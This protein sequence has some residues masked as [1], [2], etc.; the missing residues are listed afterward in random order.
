ML[1][2]KKNIDLKELEKYGYELEDDVYK[3]Y[4]DGN[5]WEVI[6]IDVEDRRIDKYVEEIG[7]WGIYDVNKEDIADLI[8]ADL[9]ERGKDNV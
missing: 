7:Y 4:I 5:R 3:K 2:I 9:I 6:Y 1:K 8:K